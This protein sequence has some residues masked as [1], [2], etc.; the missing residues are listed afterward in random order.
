M[1]LKSLFESEL[2]DIKKML[3]YLYE[4]YKSHYKCSEICEW[5][6]KKRGK[7]KIAFEIKD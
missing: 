2:K 5:T 1:K 4:N 7:R 6:Q 3:Q